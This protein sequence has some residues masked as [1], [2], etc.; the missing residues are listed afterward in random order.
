MPLIKMHIYEIIY[1][2]NAI[3]HTIVYKNTVSN[4]LYL[5]LNIL[6]VPGFY[7]ISR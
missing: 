5:R 6:V 4:Q 7:V 2:K 1:W 3:M